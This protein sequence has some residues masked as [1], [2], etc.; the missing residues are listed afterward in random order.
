[1]GLLARLRELVPELGEVRVDHLLGERLEG[2]LGRPTQ[3]LLGLGAVADQQ[4]DL[5]RPEV[6]G[7]DLDEDAARVLGVDA[8]L[9]DGPGRALVKVDPKYF[10]PTEVDLL[11]GDC[12]K[13]KK[14]LGWA[15]KVTF[16]ALAEEMVDADLAELRSELARAGQ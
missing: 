9:V 7:V 5:R 16:K 14:L 11:V 15:P 12:S 1:M 3:E 6:L 8:D 4:V 10:R 13:A 2:D